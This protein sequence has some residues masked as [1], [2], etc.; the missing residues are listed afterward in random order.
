METKT[1]LKEI[2]KK[3]NKLQ[4]EGKHKSTSMREV[5]EEYSKAINEKELLEKLMQKYKK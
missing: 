3:D 2:C 4:K 1:K 5:H